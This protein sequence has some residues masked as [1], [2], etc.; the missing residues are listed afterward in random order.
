MMQIYEDYEHYQALENYREYS[1]AKYGVVRCQLCERKGA[2]R[3]DP[4]GIHS[5]VILCK[6]CWN[7]RQRRAN[8][9]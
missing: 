2:K 5:R 9:K 6:P 4:L 1:I 3:T 7:K 8:L